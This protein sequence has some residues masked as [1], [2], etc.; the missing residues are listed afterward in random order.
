ML[1]QLLLN[2]LKEFIEREIIELPSHSYGM[3]KLAIDSK[4]LSKAQL[5][6]K[7]EFEFDRFI[8]THRKPGFRENLFFYID[9]SGLTDAEV[10]KRAC[11][12]R[13]H[14]SKIRSNP[15]YQIGKHTVIALSFALRLNE[16]QCEY[17]LNTAGYSLSLSDEFDLAVRFFILRKLYDINYINLYLEKLNMKLV[18][19]MI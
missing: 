4:E 17:L 3:P 8:D 6:D 10:Y 11:I 1:N 12:D 9:R 7:F 18:G 19:N 14:F 16:D 2:E 15:H 13:R 5:D